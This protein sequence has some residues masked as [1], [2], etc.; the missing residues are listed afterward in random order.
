[1]RKRLIIASLILSILFIGKGWCFENVIVLDRTPYAY[2]RLTV[3][4]AVVQ[5]LNAVYR[6]SSGAIFITVETNNIR[7]RVDGGNPSAINGH[8]V[9]AATYQN[10]WL[11]DSKS[12]RDFR[13]IGIGGNAIVSVTYY[14][15]N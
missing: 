3:T 7:Y 14:R 9:V 5:Q 15:R 2:E 13:M 1:M 11:T 6:A 12:I 10:L 8:L 4:N